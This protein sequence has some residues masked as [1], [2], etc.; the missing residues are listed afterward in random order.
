MIAR[1]GSRGWGQLGGRC[2]IGDILHDGRPLGEDVAIVE[3]ERRHLAFRIDLEE[4][5]AVLGFLG[6]HVDLLEI[7]RHFRLAQNDVWRERAGP[8]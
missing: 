2:L 1:P 7:E 6:A 8:R 3:R 4:V 5:A